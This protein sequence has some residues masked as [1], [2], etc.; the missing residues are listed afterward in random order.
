MGWKAAD[1]RK[2]GQ[3]P[4]EGCVSH[5]YGANSIMHCP[6]CGL[7]WSA[8]FF[9]VCGRG[10]DPN[11]VRFDSGREYQH[12]R[13]LKQRE[14]LRDISDLQL[15]PKYPIKIAG[16]HICNYVAD[17]SYLENGKRVVVDAKGAKTAVYRLKRKLMQAVHGVEVIEV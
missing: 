13:E 9:D 5:K 16:H 4:P 11:Y 7:S 1:L 6:T 3:K 2:L 8:K 17:F 12:F 10:C 14:G 15:H